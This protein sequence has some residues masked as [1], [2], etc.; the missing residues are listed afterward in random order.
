MITRTF[1][2]ITILISGFGLFVGQFDLDQASEMPMTA[3]IYRENEPASTPATTTINTYSDE[4]N[5]GWFIEDGT[6]HWTAAEREMV[7][8]VIARTVTALEEGGF[9]GD[10]LLA[11]YR[12]RRV[13]GEH[14]DEELGLVALVNHND[15]VINLADSAFLRMGGFYIYHELGHVVDRQLDRELSQVFHAQVGGSRAAE[16]QTADGYWMREHAHQDRE[17]ATADAF[18]LWVTSQLEGFRKPIFAGTPL[19]ADYQGIIDAMATALLDVS[20]V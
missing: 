1:L 16:W 20:G 11:G 9:D 10:Q 5:Q 19:D 17:E 7:N 14:V 2:L 4:G 13:A 15:Q 6:S 12:F 18:A 8:Q 3:A